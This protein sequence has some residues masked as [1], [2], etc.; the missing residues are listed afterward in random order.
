MSVAGRDGKDVEGLD[1]DSDEDGNE[2]ILA[3]ARSSIRRC[4]YP[5]KPP[6]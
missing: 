2:M 3:Q 6:G 1:E 5:C 4:R